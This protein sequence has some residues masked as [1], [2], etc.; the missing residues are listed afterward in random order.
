M[1][2]VLKQK[3]EINLE[4]PCAEESKDMKRTLESVMAK[5]R[6]LGEADAFRPWLSTVQ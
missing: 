2:A 5:R 3:W 4:N 1:Y 6:V